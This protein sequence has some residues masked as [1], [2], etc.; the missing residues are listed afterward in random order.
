MLSCNCLLSNIESLL[1]RFSKAFD[2]YDDQ[3]YYTYWQP[4]QQQDYGRQE[5]SYVQVE[6][7]LHMLEFPDIIFL[8]HYCG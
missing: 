3:R 8:D 4:D 1:R 2:Y 6:L 5:R 7:K